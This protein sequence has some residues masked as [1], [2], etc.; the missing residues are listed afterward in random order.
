MRIG[1]FFALLVFTLVPS[2]GFTQVQESSISVTPDSV[3]FRWDS[4]EGRTYFFQKSDDL[5]TWDYLS[6]I[7]LGDGNPDFLMFDLSFFI[8]DQ[9][10]IR[11]AATDIPV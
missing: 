9:N 2:S 1:N 11:I 6:E 7:R 5:V 3:E 4:V 10:F 8:E